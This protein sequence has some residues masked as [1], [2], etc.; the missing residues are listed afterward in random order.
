[1]VHLCHRPSWRCLYLEHDPRCTDRSQKPRIL[2]NKWLLPTNFQLRVTDVVVRGGGCTDP[3]SFGSGNTNLRLLSKTPPPR[4][5]LRFRC[6]IPGPAKWRNPRSILG[7]RSAP[8]FLCLDR[9]WVTMLSKLCALA[10][11]SAREA[12]EKIVAIGCGVGG[13]QYRT[14]TEAVTRFAPPH[15]QGS[16]PR[17]WHGVLAG[18]SLAHHPYRHNAFTPL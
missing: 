2:S 11:I 4:N 1:M 5:P 14:A 16:S 6:T 10:P 9:I 12:R 8:N 13:Q 17:L 3:D 15:T 18:A 7:A